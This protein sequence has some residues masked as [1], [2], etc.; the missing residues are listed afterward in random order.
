MSAASV[1]VSAIFFSI[2]ALGLFC[3]CCCCK[4]KGQPNPGS[5]TGCCNPFGGATPKREEQLAY[6]GGSVDGAKCRICK[7]EH[8]VQG[9]GGRASDQELISPCNCDAFVHRGC[10]DME[11][12]LRREAFAQC[13]ECKAFY[14]WEQVPSQVS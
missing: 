11:R 1:V 12:A 6:S 2:I 7:R 8:R 10:L 3:Y 14:N 4:F 9:C 13:P 5:G